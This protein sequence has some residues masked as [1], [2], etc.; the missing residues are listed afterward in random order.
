MYDFVLSL[1]TKVAIAVAVAWLLLWVVDIVD[2]V[3]IARAVQRRWAEF[4]PE[5]RPQPTYVLVYR[6]LRGE[7]F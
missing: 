7:L 1:L 6:I 3:R 5:Y 4:E 2:Q